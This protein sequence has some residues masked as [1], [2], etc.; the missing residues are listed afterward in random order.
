MFLR[1]F[2]RKE[3]FLELSYDLTKGIRNYVNIENINTEGVACLV[4]KA[5]QEVGKVCRVHVHVV[6][7]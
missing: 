4:L 5:R 2:G 3:S 7:K 1:G 6:C